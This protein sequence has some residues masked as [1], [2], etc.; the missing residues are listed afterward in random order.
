MKTLWLLYNCR[1]MKTGPSY[2]GA[3]TVHRAEALNHGSGVGVRG[4]DSYVDA[5]P[6]TIIEKLGFGTD[7]KE[8]EKRVDF[9]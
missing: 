2:E 3:T 4:W 9:V 1:L 8:S 5:N 7:F 6:I